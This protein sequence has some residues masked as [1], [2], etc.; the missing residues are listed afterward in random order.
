MTENGLKH[1]TEI[2]LTIIPPFW[3]TWWFKLAVRSNCHWQRHHFLRIRIKQHKSTKGKTGEPGTERTAQLDVSME[4]EKKSRDEAEDANKAKSVF[5]ATMSHEIRT[6][7][8]GI[9]GMSSLLA[10]TPLNT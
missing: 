1:I 3:L 5:L 6:P 9:I 2:K 7:M 8:N 10:Q 4:E